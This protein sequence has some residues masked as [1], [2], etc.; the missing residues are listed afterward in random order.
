MYFS[1]SQILQYFKNHSKLK[2]LGERLFELFT[3]LEKSHNIDLNNKKKD[4]EGEIFKDNAIYC[5]YL[6]LHITYSELA[7]TFTFKLNDSIV[8]LKTVIREMIRKKHV[9]LP[10]DFWDSFKKTNKD[11]DLIS[12]PIKGR[13]LGII[14]IP[15]IFKA[16]SVLFTL[17]VAAGIYFKKKWEEDKMNERFNKPLPPN[18]KLEDISPSYHQNQKQI[19][20]MVF[21]LSNVVHGIIEIAPDII[22]IIGDGLSLYRNPSLTAAKKAIDDIAKLVDRVN[23]IAI[24]STK[25]HVDVFDYSINNTALNRLD[26]LNQRGLIPFVEMN[27]IRQFFENDGV[28]GDTDPNIANQSLEYIRRRISDSDRAEDIEV[29]RNLYNIIDNRIKNINEYKKDP[30]YRYETYEQEEEEKKNDPDDPDLIPWI[31]WRNPNLNV[32]NESRLTLETWFFWGNWDCAPVSFDYDTLMDQ[33]HFKKI[34][35]QGDFHWNEENT[36]C[37]ADLRKKR[38]SRKAMAYIYFKE[39]NY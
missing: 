3:S 15:V 29:L 19:Q 38:S 5:K 21:Y 17:G 25:Q 9:C 28:R 22:E 14:V 34:L 16:I 24:P 35:F 7:R 1:F 6:N 8:D 20:I 2:E 33:T 12:F 27:R 32:I 13:M 23:T 18:P 31:I 30:I 11:L 10:T 36:M 39:F 37:I 4:H 26:I